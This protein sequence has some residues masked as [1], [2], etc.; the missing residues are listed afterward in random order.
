MPPSNRRHGYVHKCQ[1]VHSRD[2]MWNSSLLE[3]TSA[4]H[5]PIHIIRDCRLHCTTHTQ[6]ILQLPLVYNNRRHNKNRYRD[7]TSSISH[8]SFTLHLEQHSLSRGWLGR[9]LVQTRDYALSSWW[10][11]D[12]SWLFP[13]LIL[14]HSSLWLLWRPTME[15]K[16]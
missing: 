14:L 16:P 4:L 1:S 9:H 10:W 8:R 13:P 3:C 7:S 2:Y 15:H 5:T 6:K 12:S 11:S